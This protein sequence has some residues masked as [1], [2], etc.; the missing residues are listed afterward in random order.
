MRK[1]LAIVL[2]LCVG[3]LSVGCDPATKPAEPKVPKSDL[4]VP[5]KSDGTKTTPAPAPT[6]PPAKP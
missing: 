3:A 5:A 6:T 4:G 2:T 1:P